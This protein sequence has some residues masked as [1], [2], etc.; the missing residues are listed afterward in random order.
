M[1]MWELVFVLLLRSLIWNPEANLELRLRE[2]RCPYGHVIV[3]DDAV[4]PLR[5][6]GLYSFI[7]V[8]P[9]HVQANY[10]YSSTPS[11]K[12]LAQNC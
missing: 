7:G 6:T 1:M 2:L 4:F 12:A 9:F 5:T 8:H 11:S 10:W 3:D